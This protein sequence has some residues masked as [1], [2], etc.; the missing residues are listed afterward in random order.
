MDIYCCGQKPASKYKW[1]FLQD[2]FNSFIGYVDLSLFIE[3]TN[4]LLKHF[5]THLK[6]FLYILRWTLIAKF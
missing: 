5:L 1:L 4:C 3:A 2:K 6:F